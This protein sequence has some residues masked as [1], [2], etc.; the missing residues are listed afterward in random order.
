[1]K[2]LFITGS[3]GFLGGE[4]IKRLLVQHPNHH[5][6]L[7]IRNRAKLLA[8]TRYFSLINDWATELN[9]NLEGLKQRVHLVE[10]DLLSPNLGMSEDQYDQLAQKVDIVFH[11]AASIDLLGKFKKLYRTNVEGT[12]QML[13][14]AKLAQGNGGLER[15]NYV[16]TAYVSGNQR[17]VVF[18][19]D[20]DKGQSFS[21]DYELVKM[22]AEQAVQSA[23]A[24]LPITIYRPSIVVGDSKSGYAPNDCA[25]LDFVKLILTGKMPFIPGANGLKLDIIPVD[26]VV[27]AIA[28]L[29]SLT[30]EAL[31][32]T[33][34]LVAGKDRCTS[35]VDIA[36]MAKSVIEEKQG[37]RGNYGCLHLPFQLH[38]LLAI[39]ASWLC[40]RLKKHP[41][42]AHPILDYLFEIQLV[43]P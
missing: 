32:Q 24:I 8:T 19:N 37:Q 35:S 31:G 7:L 17:G 20:L 15:F 43:H 23:K 10:G 42:Q 14:F 12:L 18:E 38:P 6:Y 5:F 3:T 1:M 27:D 9:L 36:K 26:Y 28:H 41:F 21:N 2:N 4:L 25:T 29:S 16:S 40:S 33:F 13:D 39:A 34:H 30:K 11:L 22:R